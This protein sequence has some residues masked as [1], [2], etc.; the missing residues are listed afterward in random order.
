MNY[1]EKYHLPQW[2]KEDRIMM[3][4]FNRMCSDME[5]GLSKTAQDA[6]AATAQAAANAAAATAQAAANAA[7]ATAQ[8][9]AKAEAAQSAAEQA[10]NAAAAAQATADNAYSPSSKP[11]AVGS[12]E[13]QGA[14]LTITVGFRPN[15]I[16]IAGVRS[17][18]AHQYTLAAGNGISS[19]RVQFTSSG[20]TVK[21]DGST[22]SL[23]YPPMINNRGT[24]Y[25]YIAFR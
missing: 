22:N 9:A 10:A 7:A 12:Y 15:F 25:V 21:K 4:D 17:S 14:D 16:L 3:E 23:I 19:D 6:A 5:A 8:A 2:V 13:G 18:D 20:F 24:T 11:Y 1:T